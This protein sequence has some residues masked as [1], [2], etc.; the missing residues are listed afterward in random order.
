MLLTE[1]NT[2]VSEVNPVTLVDKDWTDPYKLK[3]LLKQQ[4]KNQYM[5]NQIFGNQCNC[6]NEGLGSH[7]DCPLS[8]KIQSLFDHVE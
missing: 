5:T 7:P 3:K 2:H 6:Q 8:H 1:E 4:R